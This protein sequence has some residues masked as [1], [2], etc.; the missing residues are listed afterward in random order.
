MSKL[1]EAVV[2][3]ISDEKRMKKVISE[4][5]KSQPSSS[6]KEQAHKVSVTVSDPNH[7]MITKRNEKMEK[8]VIVNAENKD[9]AVVKA[10]QY[11]T[12]KGMKVH[13]AEYHS[14]QPASTMK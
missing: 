9:Q 11:Y 2:K 5:D 7:T 3:S 13:S 6:L 14:L 10:K 4:M 8:R 12:K 1:I